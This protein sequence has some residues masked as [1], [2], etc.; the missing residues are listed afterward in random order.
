MAKPLSTLAHK[1]Y[2]QST[3]GGW[4][5]DSKELDDW[6]AKEAEADLFYSNSKVALGFQVASVVKWITCQC[7]DMVNSTVREDL[8]GETQPP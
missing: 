3:S 1:S 8:E 4:I 5:I 6:D 7:R 2:G